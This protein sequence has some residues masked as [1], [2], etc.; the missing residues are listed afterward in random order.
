MELRFILPFS[1]DGLK[2]K[3]PPPFKYHA[4]KSK[5]TMK[6]KAFLTLVLDGVM[7]PAQHL[8]A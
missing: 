3:V 4:I 2:S 1:E 6:L 5:K 7:L 8:T